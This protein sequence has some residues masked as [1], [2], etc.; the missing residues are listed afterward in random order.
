MPIALLPPPTQA[1]TASGWRPICVRHLHQA[2]VADDALE[3]AH[4]HRVRVRA[5]DGADDVEGVLDVRHP[6]AH[7]LVERVL[8]RLASRSSTGTT[9][10]PS[11][12]MR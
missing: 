7:R 6:V 10:A 11:R 8:E 9:L 5:G 2:L 1:I 4:H 12:C 3:V